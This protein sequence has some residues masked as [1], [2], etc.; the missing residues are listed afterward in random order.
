MVQP[1]QVPTMSAIDWK[2]QPPVPAEKI[3][4]SKQGQPLRVRPTFGALAAAVGISVSILGAGAYF[5]WGVKT[6]LSSEQV[7]VPKDGIPWGVKRNY[8][9]KATATKARK[10]VSTDLKSVMQSEHGRL[11]KEQQTAT[12]RIIR[13]LRRRR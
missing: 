7:H 2:E 3:D 8:E 10:K 6:H 4:W 12:E 1:I 5:Y 11:R 9:T 13:E